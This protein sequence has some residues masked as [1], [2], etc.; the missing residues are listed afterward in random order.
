MSN[1]VEIV[2]NPATQASIRV[3][4]NNPEYGVILVAQKRVSIQSNPFNVKSIGWVKPNKLTALI[5]GTVEELKDIIAANP[6]KK[7]PGKIVILESLEPFRE[8][9]PE[10]DY[11][12]AGAN[13]PVCCVDGQPIYRITYFTEDLNAQDI[14]I[15][16]NN[17]EEIRAIN[18]EKS[19]TEKFNEIIE[20]NFEL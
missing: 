17:S 19:N 11:K 1:F 3:S 6:S 15:S 10:R 16:H 8:N 7:I 13:G 4:P 9:E 5:K 18:A 12:R 14:T 20:E 2:A